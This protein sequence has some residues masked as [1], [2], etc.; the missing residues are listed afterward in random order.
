MNEVMDTLLSHRSIRAYQDRPVENEVL[1]QIL[2][3]V[4]AAPNWVNLKRI[5]QRL[6]RC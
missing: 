2:K 6:L 3:A 4:Q 1:D 5:I